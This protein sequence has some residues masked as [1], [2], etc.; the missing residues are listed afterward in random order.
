MSALTISMVAH[1]TAT[2]TRD[3]DA[4]AIVNAIKTGRWKEPLEEIRR[5]YRSTLLKIGS[6]RKAAKLAVESLKKKLPGVIWSGTFSRRAN[7]A[8]IEHSGLIC[9]DLDSLGREKADV[10]EKLLSSPYLYALFFS[11]TDDGCKAIF[12]VQTDA[13]KQLASFR[14]VEQHVLELTGIQIDPSGKDPARL[15]FVSCDPDAYLNTEAR[16]IVPLPEPVKLKLKGHNAGA[17]TKPD[18]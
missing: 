14:A 4:D 3:V 16:E 10:R 12:R 13:F 17:N 11:P 2:E 8:L 1:A 15:C 9:A 7:D 6:N 5:L 18:K